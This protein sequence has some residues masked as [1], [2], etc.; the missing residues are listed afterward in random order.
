[1]DSAIVS[2]ILTLG[3]QA[4]LLDSGS[5]VG[6]F[7]RVFVGDALTAFV[8]LLAILRGPPVTQVAVRVELA[9]LI[10]E[11]MNDFM[12]DDHADGAEIHRIVLRR[13]KIRWLQN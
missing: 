7:L 13:I 12:S 4:V 6:H 8:V 10:V 1:M 11:A 5:G 2:G 3:E 9:S